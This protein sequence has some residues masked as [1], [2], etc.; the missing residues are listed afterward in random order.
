VFGMVGMW[1]M[2]AG[3]THGGSDHAQERVVREGLCALGAR[4]LVANPFRVLAAD[5]TRGEDGFS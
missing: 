2:P 1:R 5:N 4:R 3:V